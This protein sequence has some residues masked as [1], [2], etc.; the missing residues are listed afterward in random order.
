MSAATA[1]EILTPRLG[2]GWIGRRE[3]ETGKKEMP[4]RSLITPA[5]AERAIVPWQGI[6]VIF[7]LRLYLFFWGAR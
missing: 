1:T 4:R 6:C 5:E 2:G 3:T 7:S